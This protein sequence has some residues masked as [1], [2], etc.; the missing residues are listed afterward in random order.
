MEPIGIGEIGQI[1][2]TLGRSIAPEMHV[3]RRESTTKHPC[4]IAPCQGRPGEGATGW[5]CWSCWFGPKAVKQ[6]AGT[7]L[8]DRAGPKPAEFFWLNFFFWIIRKER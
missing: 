6:R 7:S 8:V 1:G 4:S 5:S 2:G 3:G